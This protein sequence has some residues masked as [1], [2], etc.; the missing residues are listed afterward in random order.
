[1][2]HPPG[3]LVEI[4]TSR[5]G[6]PDRSVARDRLGQPKLLISTRSGIAFF[7]G[8]SRL[9]QPPARKESHAIRT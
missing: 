4:K 9:R 1:M 7:C 8:A 6:V 5:H 3:Y 2:R